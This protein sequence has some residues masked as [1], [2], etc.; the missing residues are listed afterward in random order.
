MVG[1]ELDDEPLMRLVEW[2]VR[3]LAAIQYRWD[4]WLYGEEWED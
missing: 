1:H 3:G 4:L 2:I